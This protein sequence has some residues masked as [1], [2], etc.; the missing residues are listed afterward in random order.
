MPTPQPHY[1]AGVVID[2]RSTFRET[3][4]RTL[5]VLAERTPKD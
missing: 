2:L 4:R 3:I 1:R 5:A